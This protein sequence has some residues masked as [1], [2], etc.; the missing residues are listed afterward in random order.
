MNVFHEEISINIGNFSTIAKVGNI[1]MPPSFPLTEIMTGT[2]SLAWCQ[3]K[4]PWRSHY[5]AA[6]SL[7]HSNS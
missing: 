7:Q 5:I 2:A 4:Y 6:I 3:G 1:E